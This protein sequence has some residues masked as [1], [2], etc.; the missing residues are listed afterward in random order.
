MSANARLFALRQLTGMTQ[1]AFAPII[2]IQ[3]AHYSQIEKGVRPLTGAQ[4][5]AL[6][7]RFELPETYFDEEDLPYGAASLN[8]RRRKLTAKQVAMATA[9]FGLTEQSLTKDQGPTGYEP[10]YEGPAPSKRTPAQI[11]Q[12]ALETRRRIGMKPDRPVNN[13]T[14]CM[15]RLGI[16]VAPLQNPLL[17]LTKLDGISTPIYRFRPFVS[18]LNYDVPGDRFRFSAAHELGHIV[19]HSSGHDGSLSDRESEADR[20]AAEFLMPK[21]VFKDLLTPDLTLNAF[22]QLKANWGVSIQSLVRRSFDLGFIDRE[23]YRSLNIQIANRGW[24]KNEPVFIPVEKSIRSA[25]LFLSKLT[26]AASPSD[27]PSLGAVVDLNNYR[28]TQGAR[29]LDTGQ[30]KPNVP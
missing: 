13:V 1:K 5:E 10:F 30:R 2:G 26:Q 3:Q 14:R 29:S 9:T 8:Y 20:F 18:T 16:F 21:G 24:K 7:E 17:D 23:R 15:E 6:I 12:F 11:E 28:P 22:A 25:P 4:R 19:L 27:P